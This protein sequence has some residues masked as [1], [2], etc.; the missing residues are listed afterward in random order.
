MASVALARRDLHGALDLLATAEGDESVALRATAL[1]ELARL[2]ESEALV[3]AA[4][5]ADP[6][7]R[8]AIAE[9]R[10]RARTRARPLRRGRTAVPRGDRLRRG[11]V[12][13]RLDRGRRRA[14][15]PRH[16]LQ[17]RGTVRAGARRLPASAR[18]HG[19]RGRV[20]PRRRDAVP[21]PRR[22]RACPPRLR[23]GRAVRATV[24]RAAPRGRRAGRS[25]GRR[26]R[27]R[28]GI[29]PLRARPRRGGGGTAPARP[30]ACSKP[31]SAA[32]IPRSPAPGTT[33]PPCCRSAERSTRRGTRT[34]GPSRR[35]SGSSAATIRR[36]RSR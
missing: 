35:R 1:L 14:Q 16:G 33:S 34:S 18:D 3:A 29:D 20:E 30:H 15:R 19:G 7:A 26:G 21:Q 28:V 12:R 13:R 8:L 32:T 36:S 6:R 10:A 17:V 22:A 25:R 9:C 2:D 5:P 31:R 23:G 24:R 11:A 27:S 4:E